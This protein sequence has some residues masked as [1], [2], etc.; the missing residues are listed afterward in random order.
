MNSQSNN[1]YQIIIKVRI[2]NKKLKILYTHTHTHTIIYVCTY[3]SR[4]VACKYKS[5][6]FFSN[7]IVSQPH[8]IFIL[9]VILVAKP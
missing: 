1:S 3:T 2:T 8:T 4:I 5:I 7:L 6:Y 9:L